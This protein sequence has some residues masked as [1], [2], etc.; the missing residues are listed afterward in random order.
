MSVNTMCGI[1]GFLFNPNG[2]TDAMGVLQRMTDAVAHRGPDD[3]GHWIDEVRGAALGH[4][5][6]S[7]IDLSR[8]GHQPMV[9]HSEWGAC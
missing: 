3:E 6:L 1:A 9:W 5:R 7:I 4:R 2:Y 8:M